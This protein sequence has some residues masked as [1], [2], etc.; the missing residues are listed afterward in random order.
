MGERRK[1]R[2]AGEVQVGGLRL[3][4][5]ALE[6]RLGGCRKSHVVQKCDW[7]ELQNLGSIK[8]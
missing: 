4:L 2:P 6:Q 7:F 8:F 5:E 3:G 1:D